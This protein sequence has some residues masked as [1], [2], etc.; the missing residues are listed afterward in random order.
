MNE[1]TNRPEE[2]DIITDRL[3][4]RR[5]R[6]DRDLEDYLSHLEAE[7]EYFYQYGE[8]RSEELIKMIDFH[9]A[10]VHYYTIFPKDMPVMAGY[11]GIGRLPGERSENLGN[12]EI[13]VFREYRRRHYAREASAALIKS[14]FDGSLTGSR[15]ALVEA[16][17]IS[18]NEP[19]I[20]LLESLDF[21]K[22]AVG[23]RLFEDGDGKLNA[24]CLLCRYVLENEDLPEE[25][26]NKYREEK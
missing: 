10:P 5:S 23:F 2:S 19:S 8:Q 6:D 18:E 24:A 4:L 11:V 20:L 25:E 17:T 13:H 7:N 26:L 16:E 9:S 1:K 15:G 14:F 22:D 21:K 3:V 12:L